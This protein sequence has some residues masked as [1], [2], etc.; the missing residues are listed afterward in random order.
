[1]DPVTL[2]STALTIVISIGAWF[3]DQK[4]LGCKAPIRATLGLITLAIGTWIGSTIALAHAFEVPGA[5][6]PVQFWVGDTEAH[7]FIQGPRTT[8]AFAIW[9]GLLASSLSVLATGLSL[10]LGPKEERRL[11][12]VALPAFALAIYGLSWWMFIHYSF[13]P[14]A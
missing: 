5:Y 8:A 11:A 14:S 10:V 4:I 2:L 3:F 6:G 9:G 7:R 13:F 12:R 1:M